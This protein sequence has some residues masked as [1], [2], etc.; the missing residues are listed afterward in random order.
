MSNCAKCNNPTSIELNNTPFCEECLVERTKKQFIKSMSRALDTKG[1]YSNGDEISNIK[2][3]IGYSGSL[4]SKC[5]VNLI[6]DYL[7]GRPKVKQVKLCIIEE[8]T[9]N[10]DQIEKQEFEIV[11]KKIKIDQEQPKHIQSEIYYNDIKT[12][13]I[14]AAIECDLNVV[15]FCHD[16]EHMAASLLTQVA[17]NNV[18]GIENFS[19]FEKIERSGKIVK[20]IYPLNEITKNELQIF[21]KRNSISYLQRKYDSKD[22]SDVTKRFLFDLQTQKASTCSIINKTLSKVDTK[23]T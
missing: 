7:K 2:L 8:E 11:V 14:D 17:Y 22:F 10:I 9:S 16:C 23:Y 5:C 6:K 3:L 19:L 15:V 20:V 1:K 18:L 4:A 13:L 21:S 12:I